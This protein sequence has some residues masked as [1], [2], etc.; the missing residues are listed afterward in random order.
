M[1]P[2]FYL[3]CFIFVFQM[4]ETGILIN[5]SSLEGQLGKLEVMGSRAFELLQK[6]LLPTTK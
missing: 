3:L 5:C 1:S 2:P 4:D 6:I